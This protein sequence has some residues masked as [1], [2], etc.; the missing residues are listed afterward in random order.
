MNFNGKHTK[1]TLIHSSTHSLRED[2]Q[3]HHALLESIVCL[4]IHLGSLHATDLTHVFV[5]DH[6]GRGKNQAI[7]ISDYQRMTIILILLCINPL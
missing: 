4:H 1:C 2:V 7:T 5:S 3:L 6:C